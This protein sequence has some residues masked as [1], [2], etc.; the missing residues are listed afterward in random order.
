[1]RRILKNVVSLAIGFITVMSFSVM[2]QTIKIGL[3]DFPPHIDFNEG[4][5]QSPLLNYLKN[6][7]NSADMR[8]KFVRF[9]GARGKIEL[10]KGTI[11][12]LLPVDDDGSNIKKLSLP[13]FHSIPGLC[14]KKE[15]FIPIL[16]ATH[17]FDNLLVGVPI[18]V[19][20]VSALA[21]SNALLVSVK[22]DDAI[23]RGI[24][25]TQ[26]GRLDAFYH[27]NPNKVYH[28]KNKLFKEV[29]CSSFHGYST[30]VN[31]AVSPKEPAKKFRL[32]DKAY[33]EAMKKSS[34]E[35]YFASHK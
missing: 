32:I 29:A 17:R 1:M 12:L 35:Y 2:S 8:V 31:I 21:D 20:V 18:G 14:F 30:D 22:G 33:R 28:R 11:D 6:A 13:V 15:N 5:S 10:E 3:I 19:N 9:P 23:N 24:E 7:F 16:S 4:N 27:P 34:Y 26:R 25:L